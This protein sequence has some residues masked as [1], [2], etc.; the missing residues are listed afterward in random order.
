MTTPGNASFFRRAVVGRRTLDGPDA[1]R[2]ANDEPTIR[3]VETTWSI[4]GSPTVAEVIRVEPT[5]H[6]T[7]MLVVYV[8]E[9]RVIFQGDLVRFPI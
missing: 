8:P 1:A 6:A 7:E 9:A 2:G 4:P 5:E 3:T